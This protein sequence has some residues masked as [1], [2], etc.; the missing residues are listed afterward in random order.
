MAALDLTTALKDY[1]DSV[2]SSLD[3]GWTDGVTVEGGP[4]V[5]PSITGYAALS[6]ETK[7]ALRFGF[8]L[9]FAAL[10]KNRAAVSWTVAT[11]ESGWTATAGFQAPSYRLE[12]DVVRLRGTATGTAGPIVTLPVGYRPPAKVRFAVAGAP[13]GL[14]IEITTAGVVTATSSTEVSLD[15]IAFSLTV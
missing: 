5:Y 7:D 9:T 14:Q 13:T 1:L 6:S 8:L 11:L 4:V 12:G 15:G 10:E 2:Q 3:D